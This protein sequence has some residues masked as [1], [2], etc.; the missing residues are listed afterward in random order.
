MKE[1][2]SPVDS[3][4]RAVRRSTVP[5]RPEASQDIGAKAQSDVA[6]AEALLATI[7]S[8]LSEAERRLEEANAMVERT[9][10]VAAELRDD[11]SNLIVALQ[12]LATQV[13]AQVREHASSL[14]AAVAAAEKVGAVP[15]AV[16]VAGELSA[17]VAALI[18]ELRRTADDI[19]ADLQERASALRALIDE[20]DRV[21]LAR[22]MGAGAKRSEQRTEPEE[23]ALP[24]LSERADAV[25][26]EVVVGGRG[27]ESE[28]GN[29]Y[30]EARQLAAQ[31]LAADEI[32]RRCGIGREEVRMLL[33]LHQRGLH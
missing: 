30:A 8:R 11:V 1:A 17:E 4:G 19:G 20:A 14:M 21:G 26:D 3:S 22:G 33:R 9:V 5:S 12:G 29:R 27:A 2:S 31:G 18:E 13:D 25:R 24:D 7:D 6:H 23:Q 15:T 32:A 16:P 10:A 28:K